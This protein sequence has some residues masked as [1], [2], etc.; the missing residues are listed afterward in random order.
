MEENISQDLLRLA[1][2]NWWVNGV[3]IADLVLKQ[4]LFCL[5]KST[6]VLFF[7]VEY[8]T[9]GYTALSVHADEVKNIR[10]SCGDGIE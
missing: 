9:S 5:W 2:E 6:V 3:G 4:N 1:K 10:S 7:W 8:V